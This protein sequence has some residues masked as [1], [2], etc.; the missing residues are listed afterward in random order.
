VGVDMKILS[1][2]AGVQSSTMALM[3]KHGEIETPDCAIFADTGWEPKAVYEY[4]DY[5]EKL[6]PFPVHKVKKGNLREDT[7][8]GLNIYGTRF[9]SIPF[10]TS[11][12]GMGRR[13]CTNDYK[14]QP[15]R[16][17]AREL[18]GYKPRQRI[19][20]GSVTIMIGISL[21]EASRQKPSDKKWITNTWPLLDL[22]MTRGHCIEW[23]SKNGYRIPPKSSCLLCPYHD[24]RL[25]NELKNGDKEEWQDIVFMDEKIRKTSVNKFEQF[26]HRSLKPIDEAVFKVDDKTINM[27]QNECE[28][29][30]GV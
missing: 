2:G 15:I 24:D 27:F 11:N 21:D 4:L 18:L 5:L 12:G 3:A 25:W 7:L 10:F 26:S 28:G 14:I 16:Q 19:P 29:M 1:L 6:L 20:K 22:R 8:N 23:L 30:C 9:S 13:Q 17:K